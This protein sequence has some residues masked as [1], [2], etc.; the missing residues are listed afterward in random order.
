[1]IFFSGLS[2]TAI[3][4]ILVGM[5]AGI[6]THEFSHALVADQLGD[7]RPRAMG[8]VSLNPLRHLD[9][10]GTVLLVLVGIGWGRPVPVAVEA[11]R[12]GKIGLGIVAAA[13]PVANILVAVIVAL[14]YRALDAGGGGDPAVLEVLLWAIRINL[15]LAILNLIPIP[16]LDGYNVLIALVPRRWELVIR[17]YQAYGILLLLLL[18][19]VPGS[20][21]QRLLFL[22]YPWADLLVGI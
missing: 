10:L 20:P 12:P 1:M 14:V 19:I 15:L 6:T 22:A 3:V 13:G 21:L 16:P 17:Q 4:G 2:V 8:R 18:L 7:H 11:L 9:P 5:L